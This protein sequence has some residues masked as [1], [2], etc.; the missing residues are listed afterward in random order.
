M[1]IR[2]TFLTGL[3]ALCIL[4]SAG[5]ARAQGD[6]FAPAVF[7]ND[8]VITRY[9]VEQNRQ[10]LTVLRQPGNVDE[11]AVERLIED[12]LRRDAAKTA[13]ITLT[14]EEVDAGM[15]EFAGRANLT[16]EEFL[17]AIGQN[18]V[19]PE[20]FRA[21]VEAG[22]LWRQVIG[23]RFGPR[24]QVTDAEVDRALVLASRQSGV[25]VLISELVLR[26]DSPEAEA[27]ADRVAQRLAGQF[28]SEG[29]FAVEARAR[30]VSQS[31]GAGGRLDWLPLGNLPPPIAA[32]VLGLAPGQVSQPFPVTN[33][34]VLF[35]LRDLRETGTPEAD[36]LA[37]DWAEFPVASAAEAQRVK[38]AVDTCDDLY[39][40][41]LGLPEDRLLR[42]TRTPA[43]VPSDVALELAKL[44]D[45]EGTSGFARGGQP[46]FLMLCARTYELPG[47]EPAP[48]TPAAEGESDGETAEAGAE[49]EAQAAAPSGPNREQV[50]AQLVNQR[51]SSY[52]DGYLAEL[53]ADA[54]IRYQ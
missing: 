21:F 10:F 11:L 29:A 1:T 3:L 50:R 7:V 19:A 27:E 23:T 12:A 15:A 22:L 42:E 18:G 6:L 40:E 4:I 2:Q 44:D 38:D 17:A 53:R 16:T 52:A 49:A 45:N 33:A 31:S 51:L 54:T 14:P 9:E 41:A 28:M 47:V 46:I 43:E 5:V 35:Y 37:I 20:T 39:G 34:M 32:Q 8:R 36:V 25:Q 48:E 24:A 30:S 13:G 26:A